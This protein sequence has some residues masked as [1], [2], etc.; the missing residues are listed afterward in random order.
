VKAIETIRRFWH[1]YRPR[2][3]ILDRYITTELIDPALFGLSAFTLIL[4]ATNL[5]AI[6]KLVANEHA[7][8]WAVIEYFL[9]QLPGIVVLV[10]PMA[11]LLGVLLSLQRL[12]GENEITAMKAGG[13]SLVRIVTPLLGVGVAVS[14]AALILQEGLAPFANDRATEIRQSVIQHISPFSGGTL[15]VNLPLSGGARQLTTATGYEPSTQTLVNV[16]VVQFDRYG[17][18]RVF[19]FSKKARFNPPSWQFTDATWYYFYPD[20]STAVKQAPQDQVDIGESAGELTQRKANDNPEDM[21][22]AE[23]R[24]VLSSGQLS[25]VKIREYQLTYEEKLARP[26]ACF[27]FTLL[28]IPFGLRP[29]RGGGRG[30]GFGLAVLIIFV[31][32]VVDSVVS[33]IFSTFSGGLTA[34]IGAWFPNVLFT[35]IGAWLLLRAAEH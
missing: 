16:T 33:A 15:T 28:A 20:G 27:V 30:L 12:S 29:T 21:S 34:M 9:W 23:I 1:A 31:Y 13:I 19:I 25:P 11:M 5:L 7:P 17:K 32:F 8:L 4:V 14:I 10:I 3:S 26:F 18:P 35:V 24:D 6:S 22:R 2:Y